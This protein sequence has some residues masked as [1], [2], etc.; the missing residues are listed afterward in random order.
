MCVR[1]E[2][3]D[4]V[5]DII[6]GCGFIHSFS[7]INHPQAHSQAIGRPLERNYKSFSSRFNVFWQLWWWMPGGG[8]K[9]FD[10]DAQ[11]SINRS[12]ERYL[13][14]NTY[15]GLIESASQDD[16]NCQLS[17]FAKLL[18]ARGVNTRQESWGEEN[19]WITMR[20]H[21]F[22][23]PRHVNSP[24]TEDIYIIAFDVGSVNIY[25]IRVA[26]S[27]VTSQQITFSHLHNSVSKLY[28]GNTATVNKSDSQHF[29]LLWVRGISRLNL[30]I[31]NCYINNNNWD[32]Y[33]LLWRLSS[34]IRNNCYE[35][36][37]RPFH[38]LKCLKDE[39]VSVEL[40][41]LTFA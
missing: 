27:S 8:F 17:G 35:R 16:C 6:N 15:C 3:S 28:G 13:Q 14:T 20:M 23:Y 32:E 5:T 33:N 37:F 40:G 39:S 41:P 22:N 31:L 38:L 30:V 26:V 10:S 24:S 4:L 19:W 9:T 21:W 18:T 25:S 11:M 12:R 2:S 34:W 36:H 7:A 1:L 29:M